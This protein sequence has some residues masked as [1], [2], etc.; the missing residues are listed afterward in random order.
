MDLPRTPSFR[1]EGRR[2]FVP[3]GSR[4]LGLGCA[5]ALAEAGAE[6]VI[7]ARSADAVEAAAAAMREAGHA[8][9][10]VALDVTDLAAVDAFLDGEAPFDIL[11]NAAGVARHGPALE[12]E[13]DDFDAVAALNLRAAYF[14]AQRVARGMDRGGSIIQISSQMGHV[15]GVDRAVYCAT[16]HGVEGMTKA[17]AIEWGPRD[18][19]VNTI[20]PTFIR[21][22]LTAATF[23]DPERRAW[24]DEKIKLPRVGEVEDIMGAVVFLASEASAMVTG[25][26]LLVDG[27]WTAG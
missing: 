8:A 24:I 26:S 20:C 13:P 4:G 1:L 18:I 27:G 19:R 22:P 12:T 15:G 5:V 3:G 25:T 21:T 16:K 11:C 14:L 17:M 9:T 6:V 23:A 10:G 7:A 2:A